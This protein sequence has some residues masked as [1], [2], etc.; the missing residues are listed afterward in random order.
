MEKP[1]LRRFT[2]KIFILSNI[3]IGI[4]FIAGAN[5][6]YFNPQH[7]WFLSL[8]TL[9]LPYLLLLLVLFFLF[10]LFIKPGGAFFL[11]WLFFSLFT[12]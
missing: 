2:K 8:F 12:Q 10:W 4:F 9:A 11:Y 7:W 6:K 5:V 1:I 3:L